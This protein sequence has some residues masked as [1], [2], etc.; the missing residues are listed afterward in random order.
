MRVFHRLASVCWN[1]HKETQK[2]H[3]VHPDPV[4]PP[5][6]WLLC[7]AVLKFLFS[8]P[9][10]REHRSGTHTVH[11]ALWDWTEVSF[12]GNLPLLLVFVLLPVSLPKSSSSMYLFPGVAIKK[13][14]NQVEHVPQLRRLE[15]WAYCVG[16]IT[17]ICSSGMLEIFVFD[18]LT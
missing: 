12:Y 9:W 16:R 14:H 15:A 8:W 10:L 4:D 5:T 11:R 7:T 18:W 1:Q 2:N 13:Y 6:Q 3:S 17:S